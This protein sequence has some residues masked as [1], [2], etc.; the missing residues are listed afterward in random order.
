MVSNSQFENLEKVAEVL[1]KVNSKFVFTGGAT[2]I[3]Y[4]DSL[5]QDELRITKDVDCVI[6]IANRAEYYELSKKLRAIG[7]EEFLGKNEPICR[8]QYQD[9]IIDI[10]PCDPNILGF[11][12]RWY[13]EGIAKAISTFLPSGRE[14]FVF[15]PLYLLASKIEA[16]RGRGK[17]FIFSKDIEDIITLLD[18]CQVLTQEFDAESGELKSYV[19]EWFSINIEELKDAAYNFSLSGNPSR[20]K[21]ILNVIDKLAQGQ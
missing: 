3:L 12:N 19:S 2:I 14:I 4:V 10:M 8:W 5:I 17:S 6:D 11:S 20:E 15:P 16:F 7:L 13:S 9:Q 1:S 18:G 21:L